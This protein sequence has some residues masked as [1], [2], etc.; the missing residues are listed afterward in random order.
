VLEL[1]L[2]AVGELVTEQVRTGAPGFRLSDATV[3]A[4]EEIADAIL[5]GN[6]PTAAA[7]MRRHLDE[8]TREIRT[9]LPGTD[10]GIY[11]PG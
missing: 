9:A 2:G 4:H 3:D 1:V 10:R 8:V 5:G 6:G 11:L 7:A